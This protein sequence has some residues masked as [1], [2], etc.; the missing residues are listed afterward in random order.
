MLK[1]YDS[2]RLQSYHEY[3]KLWWTQGIGEQHNLRNVILVLFFFCCVQMSESLYELFVF[4]I[5]RLI[6][7]ARNVCDAS[8]FE[9][10]MKIAN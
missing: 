1:N 9:R 3:Y 10:G 8:R 2:F 4:D 7:S 6:C 5:I